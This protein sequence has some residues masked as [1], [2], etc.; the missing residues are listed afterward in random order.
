MLNPFIVSS[1]LN[2]HHNVVGEVVYSILLV[3]KERPSL[4]NV[5]GVLQ[6]L[7]GSSGM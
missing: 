1:L 6:V 7:R 4:S 5:L 3:G 2:P